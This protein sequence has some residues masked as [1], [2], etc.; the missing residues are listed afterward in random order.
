[1]AFLD[2][3]NV[4]IRGISAC[5]P[6][7]I[8]ENIDLVDIPTLDID[9]LIKTTGVERR[10]IITPGTCM[11]DLCFA[12]AEK[13]IKELNWDKAD[14][15]GLIIVTQSPDYL[16]PATSPILQDRLGLSQ[17]CFTID[18]SL[19]CS[20]YVY[21]LSTL[22][23]YMQNGMIKKA[24]LCVGDVSSIS[25]S[26]NDK[27]TYPLFGDAGTVTALEYCNGA[28]GMKFHLSSDGS[29]Y[30]S[31]IIPAG[32]HRNKI[33]HESLK[34]HQLEQGIC[35]SD[36]QLWLDGMD[37][38]S[39][40]ISKAPDTVNKLLEKFDI[41]KESVDHFYFHQANMMMNE[42]IRKK[43]KL[44]EEKVPYSLKNFGNTSSASIPLTMVTETAHKL[45]SGV[46]SII[47]C[48]FGVG[49]S[50]ATMQCTTELLVIPDLI[51][52]E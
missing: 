43:L 7:T 2:L 29:G 8:E 33:T 40:G 17:N 16:V 28:E 31:I 41:A 20:G 32:G 13:L 25:C 46:N 47:T 39:F 18:I 52:Y 51:Y 14:I 38:F 35:R 50:W 4:I 19:G 15:E 3:K 12:A 34:E 42:R 48:G 10:H 36:V 6:S 21:G 44:P 27:S 30:K 11:S 9:K 5:V 37:V 23:S 45:R 1:M 24:L 49:L 26:K 22:G